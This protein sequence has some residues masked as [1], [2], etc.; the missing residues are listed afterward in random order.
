MET[1]KE[2][3]SDILK[4]CDVINDTNTT[5]ESKIAFLRVIVIVCER[6]ENHC[7]KLIKEI[8]GASK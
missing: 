8:K 3:T 2:Y 4:Y 5:N 7:E 6:I 1:I